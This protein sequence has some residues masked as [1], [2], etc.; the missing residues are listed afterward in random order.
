MR[1]R[2]VSAF[3][4]AGALPAVDGGTAGRLAVE[5]SALRAGAAIGGSCGIGPMFAWAAEVSAALAQMD[6]M[7]QQNSALVEQNASAAWALEQASQ[8]MDQRVGA[9][10]AGHG[11]DAHRAVG[12]NRRRI[13]S[14][15]CD[16]TRRRADGGMPRQ[17]KP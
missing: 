13:Q 7:T 17:A 3:A 11:F 15:G 14:A 10:S 8:A 9:V 12:S 16:T 4:S 1:S 5:S 2:T 6:E